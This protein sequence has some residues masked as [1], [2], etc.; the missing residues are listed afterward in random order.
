MHSSCLGFFSNSYLGCDTPTCLELSAW[1][2]PG[3]GL[4]CTVCIVL[5][6]FYL[7]L[8]TCSELNY[9]WIP[10]VPALV[11]MGCNLLI[12]YQAGGASADH[13]SRLHSTVCSGLLTR[14]LTVCTSFPGSCVVKVIWPKNPCW[15]IICK[16]ATGHSCSLDLNSLL[17]EP[18]PQPIIVNKK[19]QKFELLVGE[20]FQSEGVSEGNE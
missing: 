6:Y 12:R 10:S 1:L 9:K 8:P 19:F 7:I 18:G 17:P 4:S 11:L 3:V 20:T 13:R 5:F 2:H 15:W 14:L 16:K